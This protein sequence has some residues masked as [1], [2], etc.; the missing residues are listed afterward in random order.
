MRSYLGPSSLSSFFTRPFG[1]YKF[2]GQNL[3]TL[4]KDRQAYPKY[5]IL[6]T[7]FFLKYQLKGTFGLLHCP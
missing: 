7:V 3:E 2:T 4:V 1:F 6:A 5:L